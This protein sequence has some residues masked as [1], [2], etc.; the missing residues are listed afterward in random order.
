MMNLNQK[1]TNVTTNLRDFLQRRD[2]SVK[3]YATL[4]GTNLGNNT[5]NLVMPLQTML[6]VSEV[7]NER[8]ISESFELEGQPV[9]QRKF[10]PAHATKL[11]SFMLRAGAEEA[12]RRRRVQQLPIPP[13]LEEIRASL[14]TQ[15]YSGLQPFVANIRSC[16]PDGSNLAIEEREGGAIVKLGDRDILWM[17]DGQHRRGAAEMIFDDFFKEIRTKHRYPRRSRI[18]PGAHRNELSREELAVWNEIFEIMRSEFTVT[19]EAHL[20]LDAAQE[21]QLFHDLNNLGKKV[22]S[23]LAFEYD[24]T[25]PVNRFIKEELSLSEAQGGFMKPQIVERDIVDWHNDPGAIA[26]KDLVAVNAI[27]FLN[28]TNVSGA[29]PTT[30]EERRQVALRFWQEVN[31]IRDFGTEGAKAKTVA[32]Q[33]VVLKAL[34]KLAYEFAFGKGENPEHL[35]ILL[36]GI[37]NIDFSHNNPT[38]RYYELTASERQSRT[39]G[40]AEYLPPDT[41]GANRDIGKF[42]EHAGVMRFGSK[43]NDIFPILGDM[44][45]WSL[46]LPKRAHKVPTITN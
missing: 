8:N 30:V 23:G 36:N 2:A 41:I 3:R 31:E 20:G 10:D 39:K 26:R 40:L 12:Y 43:H 45:R 37:K 46:D 5:I 9:A 1:P 21:R 44:I 25:N 29:L 6:E 35:E 16:D 34:A 15:P 4:V 27:L 14:G 19:V 33:P 17:I 42:D 13:E 18:Y 38:W 22:E 24:N 11:G 32:A 7:A 28:K